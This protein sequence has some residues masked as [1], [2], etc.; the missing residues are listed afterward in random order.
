MKRKKDKPPPRELAE[1][2]PLARQ[3]EE[4]GELAEAEALYREALAIAPGHIGVITMLGLI[5]I[6]RDQAQAAVDLLEPARDA[7]PDFAPVQLALG[8]AYAMVGLDE[9]AVS[10]M[11]IAVKLDSTSTLPFERLAKH[12]VRSGRPREAIG[13]LRRLLRRDPTNTDAQFMLEALTGEKRDPTAAPH[14]PRPEL[15]ADLFDSYAS[16]FDAHLANLEYRVP[17][18]LAKAIVAVEPPP[19][20]SWT[21]VDLGCGTGLAGV[22]V[23]AWARTLIGSDLSSRMIVRARQRGVYDELHI[24]DLRAT[25]ER[26]RDADLI[27]AADVLIYLASLDSTF[28]AC[29]AALR[30]GGLFAFSTELG[31]GAD[32]A[33]QNTF[34][35][36]HSEPYVAGLAKAHGFVPERAEATVLRMESDQPVRGILHVYRR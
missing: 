23:R 25:L 11:E 36:R 19:D 32:I 29:A 2:L 10:T 26:V 31:E 7:E 4:R 22:E 5:L 28:A 34:R 3:H 15:V 1:L 27:V 6:D 24:E 20:R 21:V 14:E 9:L 30:P 33:L 35:Y 8:S 16:T 13:A 12:H 18:A 17:V